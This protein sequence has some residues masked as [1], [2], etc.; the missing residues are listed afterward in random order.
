MKNTRKKTGLLFSSLCI[1]AASKAQLWTRIDTL[2]GHTLDSVVV[3][4]SVPFNQVP[5]LPQVEGMHLYSGKKTNLLFPDATRANLAQNLSRMIFAQVPGVTIWEMDGAG[6]QINI[7]SRGTDTHRSIEMNMRQNGY[8]FNS[9]M[10]GYPEAH[11]TP[12]MQ[13]VQRIELVRGSAALQFGSQF[14]GMM[15]YVMKEADSTKPL[16]FE[17]EHTVGSHAFF[18]SFNAV[19][20]HKGKLSF[21]SYYNNR[22]GDDWRKNA[23]FNYHAYYASLRYDFNGKASLAVQFS[24]MD[25]VQQIAGGLTDQQFRDNDQQSFRARNFFSPEI[26][27]PALLFHYRFSPQTKLDITSHYLYGQRNSVQF[28]NTP[29]IPDTVNRS[30]NTY[31]PRQVDRDY[32]NGFTTEARLLHQYI[33]GRM[34]GTLAAGLRYFTETTK[35]RQKG[36]GTAAG[37]FD[38]TLTKPYGI[39]LHFHTDN[40]AAFAE[41]IFQLTPWLSITPG[42][43]FEVIHSSLQGVVNNATDPVSYKGK[44][45][46]PLFGT[47]LQYEVNQSTELYGNLSQAYRPYLYANVTPADRIDLVDPNLKDSK[48]YDADL[49]YRGRIRDIFKFDINGFYLFYGNRIGQLTLKNQSGGNYLFTTNVGDA[50]I[51]G[52]EAYFSVS[53]ARMLTAASTGNS[54]YKFHLFNSFSYTHARYQN[55]IVN[56]FGTNV[57]LKGNAVE[58]VPTWIN[59]TGLGWQ[60]H[61]FTAVLDFTYVGKSFS[62]ANNT[63]FNPTGATG[64]VPAY[65]LW[66]LSLSWRFARLYSISGGI[67]NLADADYFTRRINMYPGPGILPGDG[68]TFYISFGVK[69]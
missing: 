41:N 29:N 30:L 55:A 22:H 18:N 8:N 13:G 5:Y 42:A 19:G 23:A 36:T 2:P 66:D 32:Y 63:V 54:F 60:H 57:N 14:G 21:Y 24:R 10:F 33:F 7:G 4:T 31:N 40:Y 49:G 62:D 25:Y 39:D 45:N 59:R 58:G 15:N 17:S 1:F 56:K 12:P 43:R 11:Y 3:N 69:L 38:L 27:M 9:D 28:L 53:F 50:V 37:D 44:R 61:S 20:F 65:H 16:S 34:K 47:G 52:V 26:S 64:V 48:G 51:K 68:R 35:R 6:T 67:N 46:F